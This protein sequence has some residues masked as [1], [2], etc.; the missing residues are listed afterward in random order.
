MKVIADHYHEDMSL[1]K[2]FHF[3]S[4]EV[5]F[6]HVNEWDS[7]SEGWIYLFNAES[8]SDTPIARIKLEPGA[9]RSIPVEAALYIMDTVI[10][11]VQVEV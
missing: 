10:D 2:T 1:M 8:D 4:L 6:R 9:V 5:A 3:P 11:E 7:T